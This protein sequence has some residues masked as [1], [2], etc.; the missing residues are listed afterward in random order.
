MAG[1]LEQAQKMQQ[2]LLEAQTRIAQTELT[3]TA[4][5]GRVTVA[6]TGQGDVTSV[7]I[8]PSVVDPSDV[9]TLQ[10]LIVGALS[11]L[12]KKRDDLTASTM[13]PLAGGLGGGI[14]GFGGPGLGQ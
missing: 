3:G 5:G 14:P 10:D 8:D 13:G 9:E 6:G 1:L 7:T 11:D 2:Q 4:G 12:A